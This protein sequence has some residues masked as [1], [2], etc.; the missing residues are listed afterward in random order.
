MR[1]KA[2]KIKRLCGNSTL[3]SPLDNT[4]FFFLCVLVAK[5]ETVILS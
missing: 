4:A 5:V 2:T 3:L 1:I